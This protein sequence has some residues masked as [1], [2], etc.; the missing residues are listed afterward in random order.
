MG[1]ETCCTTAAVPITTNSVARTIRAATRSCRMTPMIA[2]HAAALMLAR[3]SCSLV[4]GR[5]GAS[6]PTRRRGTATQRAA[7]RLIA[8]ASAA[9][10]GATSM[11]AGVEIRLAPGWKTYWRYPGDSGVPPRFD[12]SRLATMSKSVTVLLAGA[13][14]L[15][16]RGRHLDRLQARRRVS[17][18]VVRAGSQQAGR[19]CGSSSITRSARSSACRPRQGR[20]DARPAKPARTTTRIAAE[21]SAGAE[22]RRARR[23]RRRSRSAPAQ[24]RQ[25]AHRASMSTAPRRRRRR[26]VRRRADRRTG[27]CR[28]PSRSP[29]RRPGSSASRSSSTACRP[30]P[31]R[32]ARR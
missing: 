13:A 24:A 17:A 23:R 26:S 1:I 21:R 29:A 9:R 11:R 16:R 25:A 32:T 30:I 7:V 28:C 15:H 2:Q 14:A 3:K 6:P 4:A 22:P 27:R 18:R 31:S 19:C 8:G 10:C 20:A 5:A 12:F